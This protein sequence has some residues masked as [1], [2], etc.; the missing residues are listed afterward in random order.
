MASDIQGMPA[1]LLAIRA[2]L[3]HAAERDLRRRNRR[4]RSV[5]T[6]AVGL[7]A[8]IGLSG[9]AL[10]AGAALGVID[11]GNGIQ[12][13]HVES[14]PAYDVATHQFVQVHGDYIYHLTGG[15]NNLSACPNNP[16]D[17]YV[18]STRPLSAEQLKLASEM[19][20]GAIKDAPPDRVPGLK[21]VS[22]G[23]GDAGV[24]ATVGATPEA[25]LPSQ[26][27]KVKMSQQEAQKLLESHGLLP[28]K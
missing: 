9:T 5:R 15:R 4:R 3:V 2:N 20:T 22:D 1:D 23:C 26:S 16:N 18:E 24:E 7:T 27:Q 21:S 11:L 6:A 8:A 12:A 14:Y 17:I 28:P 13:Q 25:P 19:A 10:A